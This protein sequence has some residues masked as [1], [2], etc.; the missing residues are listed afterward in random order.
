MI[1]T[2]IVADDDEIER[3]A[4]V[5]LLKKI[6][7]IRIIA[8]CE[9]ALE[10]MDIL[11][12][13]KP[14]IVFS[15]IDMPDITGMELLKNLKNPPAFVFITSYAGY[16]AESYELDAVDYIV[17]PV[18]LARLTRAV[19]KTI[20]Y[21]QLRQQAAT[22]PLAESAPPTANGA[23]FFY[24]KENKEYIRLLHT[25]VAYIESLG[26]FCK[27]YTVEG[28]THMVLVNMKNLAAQLPDV[29]FLRIQK[30]FIVNLA[31]VCMIDSESVE[32]TG[33]HKVPYDPA[34]KQKLLDRTVNMKLITR[35]L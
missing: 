17:K 8:S 31:Y 10:V 1:Y 14:D 29:V 20:E 34:Y 12:S 19:S 22:Q 15:D 6:P 5:A 18:T 21:L 11:R 30:Q 13:Q 27:I 7:A 28:R 3:E 25:Q 4:L 23:D 2:C 16:A 24:I 9:S 33:N 26:D 32:L 35:F